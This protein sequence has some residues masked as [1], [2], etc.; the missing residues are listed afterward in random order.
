MDGSFKYMN[1]VLVKASWCLAL[2]FIHLKCIISA[3]AARFWWTSRLPSSALA[4]WWAILSTWVIRIAHLNYIIIIIKKS[5][6]SLRAH[7]VPM[8]L[9]PGFFVTE[10]RARA[11]GEEELGILGG[12]FWGWIFCCEVGKLPRYLQSNIG[13]ART[14]QRSSL[15][16]SLMP[17]YFHFKFQ[18]K[19]VLWF[20]SRANQFQRWANNLVFNVR[21]Y[22]NNS[23]QMYLCFFLSKIE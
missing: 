21:I 8:I 7:F 11:Q 10:R 4:T 13:E 15:P 5:S 17:K 2:T 12:W 23:D 3:A 9:Q 18:K 6:G 22:L 1:D 20:W 19:V 16:R 14:P